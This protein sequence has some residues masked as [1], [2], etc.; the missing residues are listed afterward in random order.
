[1]SEFVLFQN[2]EEIKPCVSYIL[3]GDSVIFS[4]RCACGRFLKADEY[5]V[6]NEAKREAHGTC[7]RCGRVELAFICYGSDCRE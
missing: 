2:E 4:R 3:R 7:K 5:I 6:W 1:V